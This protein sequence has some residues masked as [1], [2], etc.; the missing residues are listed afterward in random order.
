DLPQQRLGAGVEL[1]PA[2][3]VDRRPGTATRCRGV[4]QE[5]ACGE[6][7]LVEAAAERHRSPRALL[8]VPR[9]CRVVDPEPLGFVEI[10][11]ERTGLERWIRWWSGERPAHLEQGAA[12][13]EPGS[14]S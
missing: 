3:A 11:D 1:R 4:E 9:E 5:A 14:V 6:P 8:R 12:S 13:V 2:E 10:G 7:V